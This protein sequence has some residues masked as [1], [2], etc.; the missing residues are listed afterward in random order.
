MTRH[1]EMLKITK[2]NPHVPTEKSLFNDY[3]DMTIVSN[4]QII[5]LQIT[6]NH[7]QRM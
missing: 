6:M 4:Q 2:L 3:L 5:R 7:A 1:K